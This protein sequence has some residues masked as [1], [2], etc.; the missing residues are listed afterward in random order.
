MGIEETDSL[1][2][3]MVMQWVVGKPALLPKVGQPV[4]SVML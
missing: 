2:A 4:A 1:G 3:G